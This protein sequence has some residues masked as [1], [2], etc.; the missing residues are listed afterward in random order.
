MKEL[1]VPQIVVL[2]LLKQSHELFYDPNLDHGIINI[3]KNLGGLWLLYYGLDKI[4][5]VKHSKKIV[6]KE[7]NKNDL[8]N[9]IIV[10]FFITYAN[11]DGYTPSKDYD[12]EKGFTKLDRWLLSKIDNFSIRANN[13]YKEFNKLYLSHTSSL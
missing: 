13:L 6:E 8:I 12:I 11:L 4:R 9:T 2:S 7:N 5:K 3:L 1:P 10:V